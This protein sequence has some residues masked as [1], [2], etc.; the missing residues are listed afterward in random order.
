MKLIGGTKAGK[1][2]KKEILEF[3]DMVSCHLDLFRTDI[4]TRSFNSFE[5]C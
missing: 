3:P 5:L 2:A 4:D 1:S